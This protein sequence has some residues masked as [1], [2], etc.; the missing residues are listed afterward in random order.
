[1]LTYK[2]VTLSSGKELHIYDG[3]V[4]MQTRE[5]VWGYINNST[6]RLGWQDGNSETSIR[7]KFLYSSFSEQETVACGLLPHLKNT[8]VY[9]HIRDLTLVKSIVNLSVP[10]DTHFAHTHNEQKV[11]LYYPNPTWE[12][13]WHG[14]TVFYTEDLTEIELAIRYTPGRVVVFDANIPHAMRPQSTSA[15]HYRFTYAMTFN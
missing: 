7:H 5:L 11:V 12:H 13:H 14:E 3:L 8:P 15:D 1:M 9:E 2:K 10:S 4:P 6:F